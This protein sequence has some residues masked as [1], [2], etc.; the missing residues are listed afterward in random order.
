[1]K[2]IFT[3]PPYSF[4]PSSQQAIE[5][6]CVSMEIDGDVHATKNAGDGNNDT[7]FDLYDDDENYLFSIDTDGDVIFDR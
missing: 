5:Q 3:N 4:S 2:T 7:L 6:A 1:M